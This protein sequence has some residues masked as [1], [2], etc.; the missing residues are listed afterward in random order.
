MAAPRWQR[1]A[2]AVLPVFERIAFGGERR[3]R[4]LLAA[5]DAHYRSLFRRR[6][7]YPLERPHHFDHRI[8]SFR[9][10]IGREPPFSWYRGFFAAELVRPGDTLLDLGCGDGFFARRFYA[11]RCAAVDA[12]DVDPTAIAHARRRNAAPNVRYVELD[13]AAAPFPRERY[14]VVVWDG[15]LAHFSAEA[16]RA[17]LGRISVALSPGGAFSGSESLGDEGH[18]HL[19]AFATLDDLGALL[20]GTF[21]HVRV[22]QLEYEVAGGLVRREAFWR[23]AVDPERLDAAS[24]RA[25]RA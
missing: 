10:A 6:W 24:W 18:D 1:P 20:A 25:P 3:E 2:R 22:R 8:G 17:M 7:L 11:P 19:Q 4:L 12:V 16:T 21:P 9:F 23:C 15:A 13:A 14:D 5:L